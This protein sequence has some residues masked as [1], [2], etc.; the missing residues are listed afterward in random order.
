M[1][2]P[3]NALTTF[4]QAADV[5]TVVSIIVLTYA[6]QITLWKRFHLWEEAVLWVPFILAALLT[7]IMS[8]AE[9]TAW[10]GKYYYRAVIYNGGAGFFAWRVILPGLKSK[11]PQW[12]GE[13]P[14][15]NTPPAQGGI[16]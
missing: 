14:T 2:S 15:P 3:E 13:Q 1:D 11:Y 4:L 16:S 8:S 10:G 12:F 9:E 6:L 7:P 5:Q